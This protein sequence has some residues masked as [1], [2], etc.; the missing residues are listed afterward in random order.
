M[1]KDE[2]VMVLDCLN[3]LNSESDDFSWIRWKAAYS[4]KVIQEYKELKRIVI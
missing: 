4:L 1:W 2:Y 3:S